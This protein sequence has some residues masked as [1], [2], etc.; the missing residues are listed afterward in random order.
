MELETGIK[1][2]SVNVNS[3]VS[4]SRRFNLT[5]FLEQHDPDI[6]LLNETKLNNNH[7]VSFE[8]YDFIRKDRPNSIQ[9]GGTGILIKRNFRYERV[10]LTPLHQDYTLETCAI[11]I[12]CQNNKKIIIICT[13]AA[14]HNC[15]TIVNEFNNLFRQLNLN[16]LNSYFII[17]GD[18]NA[19][20][21]EW[22]D[23]TN[24]P[25][26]NYMR[27]WIAANSI[28]YRFIV[29]T[30]N[31]STFKSSGSFLDI[32]LAD[33]RLKLENLLA[34]KLKTLDYDSDHR[35]IKFQI[36]LV[37]NDIRP[38]IN[39]DCKFLKNFK[40]TNW[41]RFRKNLDALALP[42]DRNL[43][44]EEIDGTLSELKN[45][46]K[47]AIEMTTPIYKP[48]NSVAKYVNKKIDK[49]H[50]TKSSLL[51]HLNKLRRNHNGNAQCIQDEIQQT[52]AQLE[53]IRYEINKE[54]SISCNR[55][56]A[57]KA[58]LI[59]YKKADN[60][61]PEINRMFR[62]NTHNEVSN[63]KI[64]ADD[65][66]QIERLG[67]AANQ[68]TMKDGQLELVDE[69]QI[70]NALGYQYEKVNA[71]KNPTDNPR[72]T[73]LIDKEI[74]TLTE[75]IR[76]IELN[77]KTRTIFT[78]N[79]PAT[80]PKTPGD[81]NYSIFYSSNDCYRIFKNIKN[82]TSCGVDD[83]PNV[84]LKN[85][86]PE[87]IVCYTVIFNNMIN[88][89]YYPQSWKMAKVIPLLKKGKDATSPAS[90]RPIS[91]MP[92]DSKIFE[93]LLNIPLTK[94][95]K[96]NSI[97]PNE[98][99]GFR[100]KH[101][102]THA[103]SK[104]LT[105]T[106]YHLNYHQHIAA[107]L[108]DLE[109]AFDSVWIK[110]LFYKLIKKNFPRHLIQLL[111]VM[112]KE[113]KFIVSQGRTKSSLV[114]DVA[115]GL[116]QGTV[117][118]PLLFNIYSSDGLNLFG[119]NSGNETYSIAFA[120][121]RLVYIAGKHPIK[122]QEK[123][124][125]LVNKVN[126]HY[127]TWHMKVNANKCETLLIRLPVDFLGRKEKSGWREFQIKIKDPKDNTEVAVPHKDTVK[128]LGAYID[129]LLRLTKHLDN[130][131][132]KAKSAFR[133]NNRLF[134]NK[135]LSKEAKIIC[136][137]LL[138]RPI[139]TYAIPLWFNQSASSMERIRAFE[140]ACIRICLRK[141]RSTE[142]NYRK[143]ISNQ[144][145]YDEA[146]IPRIDNFMIKLVREHHASAKKIESNKI[147]RDL[148]DFNDSYIEK[149]MRTGYIPPIGFAALD[150][151]GLI[152]DSNNIP[153]IYHLPRHKKNKKITANPTNL[154][155]LKYSTAIPSRDKDDF[156]RLRTD[157]YW[158]LSEDS[159][160]I[161]EIRRRARKK[162]NHPR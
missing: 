79:N 116:Q 137:C 105:D 102:T 119:L 38:E 83:I 103:I 126:V 45:N 30:P 159:A 34:N 143:F 69:V 50:K 156:H 21:V 152:Q 85:L 77:H 81:D 101:S 124:E 139:I 129:E 94:F 12:H 23:S 76:D 22:G 91:L 10:I 63:I 71:P 125:N 1:V 86:P 41:K 19:R 67:L 4:N 53:N 96:D 8:N 47:K 39:T 64:P 130:Q 68:M 148:C 62:P 110:G 73:E 144:K 35:A 99:F 147:I 48:Q 14:G 149:G 60:F 142:S 108:L 90:Y 18:L 112:L 25:R 158:W 20:L 36:N 74:S 100:H 114:F 145:L 40:K 27:T 87:Y 13:Y 54:F 66:D 120:D 161:A 51:S 55:F 17:A 56:W 58:K 118:A 93:A 29:Y 46:I 98:Q 42:M 61:F 154:P 160:H 162:R 59:D 49:L 104:F 11:K 3:I 134:Y 153:I 127:S 5:N 43:S 111:W 107:C 136:Y 131:L 52:K 82:K 115:E 75:E 106:T 9:G 123:L 157:K 117:N 26:G 78:E 6:L 31:E 155:R 88:N 7:K 109:K 80:N 28:D 150:N 121:D 97:L 135:Y 92:N 138:I 44:N 113:R 15:K 2:I 57:N 133:A 132:I 140:R 37:A 72:L 151:K 32:C 146:Q 122:T 24:N 65:T 128:Y 89:T 141:H 70:L 33:S 16:Q 84:V 95:C